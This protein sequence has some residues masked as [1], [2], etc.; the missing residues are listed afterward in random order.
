MPLLS[1]QNEALCGREIWSH[2]LCS[3][4]TSRHKKSAW[5]WSQ[6]PLCVRHVFVICVVCSV[7]VCLMLICDN[8]SYF[9]TDWNWLEVTIAG[10]VKLCLS[11]V[12]WCE[13]D[14]FWT[15]ATKNARFQRR[16][17]Q[18]FNGTLNH[19]ENKQRKTKFCSFPLNFVCPVSCTLF[20]S[21]LILKHGRRTFVSSNLAFIL[22]TILVS[23]FWDKSLEKTTVATQ[24][25]KTH[26]K[27]PL[28]LQRLPPG[29][30]GPL[31]PGPG[32]LGGQ[33]VP[34]EVLENQADAH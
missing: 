2:C 22:F 3:Y 4:K 1:K 5:Q 17:Y 10:S 24:L 6:F 9:D 13:P 34:A 23:L 12:L 26:K 7:V 20:P 27:S 33:Q 29:L 14:R 19:I 32:L 16:E 21:Q 18:S 25:W 31:H 15:S 30:P 8:C 11:S 28:S